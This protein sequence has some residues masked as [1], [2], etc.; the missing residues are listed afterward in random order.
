MIT[1]RNP[2]YETQ[3]TLFWSSMTVSS[4]F[5]RCTLH[6]ENG[7]ST[8]ELLTQ[9]RCNHY[10]NKLQ[11]DLLSVEMV[12]RHEDLGDLNREKNGG[13]VEHDAVSNR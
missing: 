2:G 9:H 4:Q 10:L 8:T 12:F 5:G 1:D 7:A 13:E 6:E 11:A 3:N